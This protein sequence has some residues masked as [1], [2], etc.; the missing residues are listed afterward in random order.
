MPA[1]LINLRRARKQRDRAAREEQAA[2]N[3]VK[4]GRTKAERQQTAAIDHLDRRR[5]D[6]QKIDAP[7]NPAK[8][9]DDPGRTR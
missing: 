5:L 3:R 4:F 6:A 1:D 2:A 7:A 9:D 8:P